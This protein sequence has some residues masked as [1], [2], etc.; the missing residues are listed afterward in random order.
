[1]FKMCHSNQLG[2]PQKQKTTKKIKKSRVISSLGTWA[3]LTKG[4]IEGEKSP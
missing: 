2:E 1:M 3:K 4:G